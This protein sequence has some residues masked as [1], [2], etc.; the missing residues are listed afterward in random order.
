[1]DTFVVVT[2]VRCSVY[3]YCCPSCGDLKI[4]RPSSTGKCKLDWPPILYSIALALTR[5]R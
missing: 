5:A 2:F 4:M 3:D 1:M